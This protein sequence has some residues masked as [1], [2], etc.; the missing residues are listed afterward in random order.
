[1]ALSLLSSSSFAGQLVITPGEV[2]SIRPNVVSTVTCRGRGGHEQ[3]QV[4]VVYGVNLECVQT[5]RDAYGS[6]PN[7]ERLIGWANT[8]RSSLD[9]NRCTYISSSIDN[10][11][12]KTLVAIYGSS[13]SGENL[14][15]VTQACESKVYQCPVR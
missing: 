15:K 8:C 10:D 13:P 11:C 12:V 4:T 1:M 9:W 7:M 14:Q 2:V 5:Q 3:E 6:S